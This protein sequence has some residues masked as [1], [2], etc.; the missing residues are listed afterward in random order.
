MKIIAQNRRARYDY[1]L[2][3]KFE[4]GIVLVG[5]EVKSIRAGEVH[6]SEAY[7]DIFDTEVY[8]TGMHV[9]HY[10]QG[11]QFNHEEDRRRKLLLNKR[12]IK[13]LFD[14]SQ[15]QGYTI[16]PTKI[17]LKNGLV[18]LEIAIAKGKAEY[19]KRETVKKRDA[20]R[21]IAKSMKQYE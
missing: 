17:Y 16:I 13:K 6:L 7:V 14:A 3:Q 10:R 1:F 11:N 9:N 20:Q 19:D 5:T 8:I 15:V 4:A 18:K 21:E 12:E 2:E